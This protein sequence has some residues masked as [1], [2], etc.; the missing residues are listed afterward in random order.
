[1]IA[2]ILK[3]DPKERKEDDVMN[4]KELTQDL[5]FFVK[6]NSKKFNQESKLHEKICRRLK[7]ESLKK[8]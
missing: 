8:G 3:M 1:M 2:K 7:Y 6:I 4:L 5:E